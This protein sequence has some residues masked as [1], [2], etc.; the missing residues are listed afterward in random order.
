MTQYYTETGE[1][2]A[3][4]RLMSEM[5][6]LAQSD[7]QQR[8]VTSSADMIACRQPQQCMRL[9]NMTVR[10]CV[11]YTLYLLILAVLSCM[12]YSARN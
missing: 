11:Y 3:S 10:T 2:A 5:Y 8:Y 12:L 6:A 7:T 1:R 9:T 4:R